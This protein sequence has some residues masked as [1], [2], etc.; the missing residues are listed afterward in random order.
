MPRRLAALVFGVT[1]VSVHLIERT[2]S[3]FIVLVQ[4]V[5]SQVN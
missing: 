3:I 1:A 4:Q 2:A 5:A